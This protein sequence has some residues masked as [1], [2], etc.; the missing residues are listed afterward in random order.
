ME[1]RRIATSN[2]SVC[3]GG[4]GLLEIDIVLTRFLDRE[5]ERWSVTKNLSV[6]GTR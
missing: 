2:V 4:R 5:G 3:A 1:S 6:R